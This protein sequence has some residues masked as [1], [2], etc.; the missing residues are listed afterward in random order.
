M[1]GS[2]SPD[3]NVQTDAVVEGSVS[4]SGSD[5]GH[6]MVSPVTERHHVDG[7]A[8]LE[9][10]DLSA[11]TIRRT[12]LESLLWCLRLFRAYPSILLLVVPLVVERRLLS[13]SLPAIGFLEGTITITITATICRCVLVRGYVDAV[14]WLGVYAHLD[15]RG[16]STWARRST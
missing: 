14:A 15:V 1:S 16:S 11:E 5:T 12:L 10:R 9:C 7:C 2:R 13:L 3:G 6:P 4:R 8:C